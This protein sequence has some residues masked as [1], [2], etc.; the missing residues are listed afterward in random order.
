[1]VAIPVTHAYAHCGHMH[2]EYLSTFYVKMSIHWACI[3]LL[4]V[5]KYLRQQ[6][7]IIPNTQMPQTKLDRVQTYSESALSF[8][9]LYLVW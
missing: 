6:N 5:S 2:S 8:V 3:L 9:A 4:H 7:G 1:M